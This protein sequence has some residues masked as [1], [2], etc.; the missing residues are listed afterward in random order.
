MLTLTSDMIIKSIFFTVLT[1]AILGAFFRLIVTFLKVSERV[2]AQRFKIKMLCKK[3]KVH[4]ITDYFFTVISG[5]SI[6]IITYVSLDG[7][8][9]LYP[10]VS[11]LIGLYLSGYPIGLI[12]SKNAGEKEHRGK[13]T[14]NAI[15]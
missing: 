7:V 8:F 4:H 6:I 5:I 15:N 11:F 3:A 1:G 10:I 9:S 2:L 14:Q 13:K 12:A